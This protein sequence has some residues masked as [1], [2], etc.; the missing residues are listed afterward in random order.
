MR[1]KK[2]E[3]IVKKILEEDKES[4]KD[5]FVLVA[6]VYSTL[7]IP[8]EKQ[9]NY[10]MNN[11]KEY[12]LPSFESITRVRRKIVEIYPNLNSNV[13]EREIE[14]Q[15]FFEYSMEGK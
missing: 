9:F 8:I 4:R 11:H 15:K 7:G 1:L 12:K 10:L 2:L 3:T 13:E 14:E 6:N 5:N